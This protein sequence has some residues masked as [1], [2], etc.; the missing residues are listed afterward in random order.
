VDFRSEKSPGVA[1]LFFLDASDS[2]I[3]GTQSLGNHGWGAPRVRGAGQESL[4]C[5]VPACGLKTFE[6]LVARSRASAL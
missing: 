4:S 3:F 1:V 5:G 2:A 6:F